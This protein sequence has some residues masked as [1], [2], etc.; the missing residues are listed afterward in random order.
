MSDHSNVDLSV[1]D[2]VSQNLEEDFPLVL[3]TRDKRCDAPHEIEWTEL[4]ISGASVSTPPSFD[5]ESSNGDSDSWGI[6]SD[7]NSVKSFNTFTSAGGQDDQ[8]QSY[9]DAVLKQMCVPNQFN[10]KSHLGGSSSSSSSSKEYIHFSDSK[11]VQIKE[12]GRSEIYEKG[13]TGND[14]MIGVEKP[15]VDK[16][17]KKHETV[18]N[19][20]TLKGHTGRKNPYSRWDLDSD[21]MVLVTYNKGNYLTAIEIAQ[22][23]NTFVNRSFHQNQRWGSEISLNHNQEW[24]KIPSILESCA[25]PKLSK[26]SSHEGYRNVATYQLKPCAIV[27]TPKSPIRSNIDDGLIFY[28]PWPYYFAS[29]CPPFNVPKKVFAV[30]NKDPPEGIH[31]EPL[32]WK[33]CGYHKTTFQSNHFQRGHQPVLHGSVS[34]DVDTSPLCHISSGCHHVLDIDLGRSCIVTGFSTQGGAPPVCIYPDVFNRILKEEGTNTTEKRYA[35]PFWN[36]LDLSANTKLRW[37]QRYMMFWRADG[38][39]EWNN[40]GTFNGND[41]TTTEKAH[42]LTD[43]QGDFHC[44]YLRFVPIENENGGA[45]RIQVYGV[46]NQ[47]MKDRSNQGTNAQIEMDQTEVVEYKL[48]HPSDLKAPGIFE[49]DVFC[50]GSYHWRDIDN[51]QTKRRALKEQARKATQSKQYICEV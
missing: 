24:E 13:V 18:G 44:R 10:E 23:T 48:C 40:M 7:V 17:R 51:A 19:R 35:G 12:R 37:V 38:G 49:R 43:F 33:M 25:P 8:S 3:W 27:T 26:E 34:W 5:D 32:T 21:A 15:F 1:V 14:E 50:Y 36:V 4:D 6:V 20:R 46:P 31:G 41:D 28:K 9:R 39:R 45:M 22:K 42:T 30:L 47:N 11:I 2:H 16:L 29:R